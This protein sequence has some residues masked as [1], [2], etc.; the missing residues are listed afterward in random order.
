[1]RKHQCQYLL[2]NILWP[3]AELN[4]SQ[5]P[6]PE[7]EFHGVIGCFFLPFTRDKVKR[8]A[9]FLTY[10]CKHFFFC[11]QDPPLSKIKIL[12]YRETIPL[13]VTL[14]AQHRVCTMHS[15]CTN[16]LW[17]LFPYLTKREEKLGYK[18]MMKKR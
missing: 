14:Q 3:L 17:L 6:L 9:P 13:H 16:Q 2:R 12:S 11:A 1:M 8:E 18:K 4:T 7:H 10:Q 15:Q 5:S